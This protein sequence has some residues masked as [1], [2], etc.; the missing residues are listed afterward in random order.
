MYFVMDWLL[1]LLRLFEGVVEVDW[2]VGEEFCKPWED[3][4]RVT[5]AP[6]VM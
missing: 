3:S 6:E 2:D 1:A 5:W 4:S